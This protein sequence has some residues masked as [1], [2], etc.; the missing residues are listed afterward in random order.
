[1]ITPATRIRIA[2]GTMASGRVACITLKPDM[3]KPATRRITKAASAVGAAASAST[4]AKKMRQP[5]PKIGANQRGCDQR[6]SRMV[7]ITAPTPSPA[8]RT[9]VPN[10]P[11]SSRSTASTGRSPR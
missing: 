9:P 6:R 7:A 5:R 2:A 3:P 4:P 10:G 11:R 8:A 1:M